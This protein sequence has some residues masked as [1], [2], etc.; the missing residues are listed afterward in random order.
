MYRKTTENF[1]ISL[2]HYVFN[3]SLDQREKFQCIISISTTTVCLIKINYL[4]HLHFD[5]YL[6]LMI[7]AGQLCLSIDF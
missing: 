1:Q 7:N 4:P 6:N 3:I 2:F 5:D